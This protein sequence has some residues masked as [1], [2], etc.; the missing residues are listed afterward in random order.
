[1]ESGADAVETTNAGHIHGP[2]LALRITAV[3]LELQHMTWKT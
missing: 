2:R 3:A 1:M